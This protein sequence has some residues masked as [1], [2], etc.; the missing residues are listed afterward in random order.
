MDI[1]PICCYTGPGHE[2]WWLGRGSLK[3]TLNHIINAYA[4]K[5]AKN[6]PKCAHFWCILPHISGWNTLVN[7]PDYVST[8]VFR[9]SLLHLM[10]SRESKMFFSMKFNMTLLLSLATWR[11]R[12]DLMASR[13]SVLQDYEGRG[14]P[15]F[16]GRYWQYCTIWELTSS[17]QETTFIAHK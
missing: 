4:P 14:P 11:I 9:L 15:M 10:F 7:V 8:D 16:E 12:W 17:Y 5:Y 1:P 3:R 6:M 2:A 13:I